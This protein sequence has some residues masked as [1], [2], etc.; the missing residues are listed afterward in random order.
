MTEACYIRALC[1]CLADETRIC[2]KACTKAV[3]VSR[4]DMTGVCYMRALCL[5]LAGE[6]GICNKACTKV[7]PGTGSRRMRTRMCLVVMT[8]LG[9]F[10]WFRHFAM[11]GCLHSA[12]LHR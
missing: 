5:C 7:V 3:A 10:S 6:S 9:F 2:N 11:T 4:Y 12:G 1:L 8:G